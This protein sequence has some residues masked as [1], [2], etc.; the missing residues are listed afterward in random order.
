MMKKLKGNKGE[1]LIE[2]LVSLLIAVLALGLV[3]TASISA[4][5][6]N[7]ATREADKLFAEEL[8]I[9]EIQSGT[10]TQT[11]KLQITL[12]VN[13]AIVEIDGNE[14]V[15]VKIYGDGSNFASYVKD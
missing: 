6:M 4:T 2:A 10:S 13:G 12:D 14:E 9:A 3:S 8:E 15:D 7:K 11:R 5:N 1:T